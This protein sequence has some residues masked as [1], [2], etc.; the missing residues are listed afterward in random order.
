MK[1]MKKLAALIIAAAL[2]ITASLPAASMKAVTYD[3]H[4]VD[5]LRTFFSTIS[6]SGYPNGEACNDSD[7][8]IDDPAS[9]SCC[10]WTGS[11]KLKTVSFS[12]LGWAVSGRLD[13]SGC[14]GLTNISATDCFI[15]SVDV[16]GCSALVS[17]NL[18]GDLLT[19]IDVSTCPELQLLWLKKN[20][21]SSVDLSANGK[22]TSLDVSENVFT[23]LDVSH[24]PLLTV[25]R[26]GSNSIASLDLGGCTLITELNVKT[27]QLSELDL[28][29]M[30]NLTKF[31]SFGNPLSLLD[32]SCMNGGES[33][34]IDKV[35]GGYIG[36]RVMYLSNGL[37]TYASAEPIDG[38][39]FLGWYSGDELIS[40]EEWLECGFGD[41]AK[42]LTARFTGEPEPEP[43]MGDVDGDGEVTASD[44]LL[45]LRYVLDVIGPEGLHLDAADVNRDGAIGADDC[46]LVLRYS[47]GIIDS[48]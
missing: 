1:T 33:F 46:L 47:M 15:T 37:V 29:V 21:I 2:M 3:Q 13:L 11:G 42:H 31:I 5:K 41:G 17:L 19:S 12:N 36:T 4:D 30:T 26:C 27:N 10:T 43:L 8:N 14:T 9:W 45:L 23:E 38:E 22:L 18:T 16:T 7:Y 34:V 39:T 40:S 20:G 25:L 44:A 48:F 35:G 24:C 28:S 6:D 32:I